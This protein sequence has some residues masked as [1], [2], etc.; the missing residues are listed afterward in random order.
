ML[1]LAD[2][3]ISKTHDHDLANRIIDSFRAGLRTAGFQNIAEK[4]ELATV[5][6]AFKAARDQGEIL[7]L[8]ILLSEIVGVFCRAEED[9]EPT[10]QAAMLATTTRV[11][12]VRV[13]YQ[14][15][16]GPP[17]AGGASRSA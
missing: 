14:D 4:N 6:Q 10:L 13:E 11:E 8:E 3:K 1:E 15:Q 2:N 5:L 16:L 17:G 9:A 12:R 7:D